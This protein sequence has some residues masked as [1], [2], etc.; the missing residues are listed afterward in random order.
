[1]GKIISNLFYYYDTQ[2][3][4]GLAVVN[5]LIFIYARF[6]LKSVNLIIHPVGNTRFGIGADGSNSKDDVD[7]LQKKKNLVLSFYSAYANITAIFP[8]L[9]IIGTVASLITISGETDMMDNLMVALVTTLWGVFFAII[10]KIFDSFVSG[11]IEA[12]VDDADYVIRHFDKKGE[13]IDEA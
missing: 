4:I 2:I 8:L 9:G 7:E 10:F 1:M 12:F 5:A 11:P 13:M 3:I 6:V